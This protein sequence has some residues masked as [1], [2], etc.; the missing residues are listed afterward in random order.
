M[1]DLGVHDDAK[2]AFTRPIP[3]FTL[4]RNGCSR[5]DDLSVHDE[6][7]SAGV[8]IGLAIGNLHRRAAPVRWQLGANL[9]FGGRSTSRDSAVASC[10]CERAFGRGSDTALE[11]SGTGDRVLRNLDRVRPKRRPASTSADDAEA[12]EAIAT[13]AQWLFVVRTKQRKN[14][15]K[16]A[17]PTG[18]EPQFFTS[19]IVANRRTI[20][21]ETGLLAR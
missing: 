15:L 9:S 5:C 1:P 13:I 8:G 6:A 11:C 14:K 21:R 4:T 20:Q 17:T 16:T 19:S 12:F 18:I 3:A 7:I 2:R 10:G